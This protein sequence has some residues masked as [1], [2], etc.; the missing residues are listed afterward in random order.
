M[1]SL[2]HIAVGLAAGK[3]FDP[4]PVVS[5][6]AAIAFT[7]VSLW[8]DADAI[9]FVFKIPYSHPFGH[10]GA[11][12]SLL[13]AL[14]IGLASALVANKRGLDVKRTVLFTT[15]VAAS[16]GLL[17]TITYGGGRGCA[18]LWPFSDA[19]F[20]APEAMRIIPIAPIGLELLSVGGLYVMA[21]ELV[22]FLPFWIYAFRKK[23]PSDSKPD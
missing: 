2:G 21:V 3:A 23:K 8:P 12:H 9:A 1:A 10:R 17:D 6:R 4:D 11:T 18:L 13:V 7:L 22:F 19:R 15:V 20:W 5:R 16:H 14:A